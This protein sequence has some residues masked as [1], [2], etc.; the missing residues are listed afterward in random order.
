MNGR[1]RARRQED[2]VRRWQ[3]DYCALQRRIANAP[4][5]PGRNAL[6]GELTYVAGRL[7]EYDRAE[8]FRNAESA[9]PKL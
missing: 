8:L 7:T 2:R 5:G 3:D 4:A 1:I 9:S 6:Y